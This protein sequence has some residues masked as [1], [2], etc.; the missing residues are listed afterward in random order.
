MGPCCRC[1]RSPPRGPAGCRPTAPL[2]A[3]EVKWDGMRVARGRPRGAG[4][5]VRAGAAT[6]SPWPSPS[7]PGSRA[8]HQDVL[9]DGEVVRA[10]R[11]RPELRGA[12]GALPRPRRPA[13]GSPGEGR[14]GHPHRVRRAAPVRRRPDRDARGRSGATR[15]SGSAPSG[16]AWQL[17]PVVRRRP[18]AAGGDPAA[19]AG[20]YRRQAARLAVPGGR[21]GRPTGSSSRTSAS[22]SCVVGGWRAETD[23]PGRVGALLLGLWS[24]GSRTAALRVL[25]TRGKAG[26]G[27]ATASQDDVRGLLASSVATRTRRSTRRVPRAR[28]A[29]HPLAAARASSS[30]SGTWGT[31]TAAACASPSSWGSAPTSR[32]TRGR[33]AD[34]VPG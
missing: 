9:L 13:C 19:G 12:G 33:S 1:S 31:P 30:T 28:R 5:A 27:L 16:T 10:A 8:A 4:A 34:R 17:S 15:S 6:T 2:W 24:Q 23:E 32:P 21:D 7:S 29:R 3:Y 18:G 20:G 11:R 14:P 25:G 22:Q 26:S